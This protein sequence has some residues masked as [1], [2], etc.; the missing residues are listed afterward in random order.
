MI[1]IYEIHK[2][3]Q[4]LLEVHRFLRK[5]TLYNGSILKK[6]FTMQIK[7]LIHFQWSSI[8]IQKHNCSPI[9]LL[10]G[11]Y[12]K[13]KLLTLCGRNKEQMFGSSLQSKGQSQIEYINHGKVSDFNLFR[14]SVF[15]GVKVIQSEVLSPKTSML[16]WTP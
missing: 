16:V 5:Y 4:I 13:R 1:T 14:P 2:I 15:F 12:Y 8:A 10:I 3:F 11:K 9:I 7:M 6:K